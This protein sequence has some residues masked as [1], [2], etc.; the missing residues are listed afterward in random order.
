MRNSFRL[1]LGSPIIA[2]LLGT[3]SAQAGTIILDDFSATQDVGLLDISGFIPSS[4]QTG[5]NSSIL[6]GFR[7]LEALGNADNFLETRLRVDNGVLSFSN[8]VD[9]LGAGSIVWDG[10]DDPTTVDSIGLGGIDITQSGGTDL[11]GIFLDILSADLAGLELAFTVY[12]TNNNTSSLAQIFDTPVAN[13]SP[14]TAG[15]LF[16]DFVG[17]AD[18]T[19]VGAIELAIAGPEEIDATIDLIEIAPS[20]S[21][22]VPEPML[23]IF[24]L[25]GISILGGNSLKHKTQA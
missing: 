18:F 3:G 15:F 14:L 19:N 21:A 2:I 20:E 17:N 12:D 23:S 10:N 6:G 5:P 22:D 1:L 24:A 9:T 16:S 13:S 25:V 11:D 4:S 8:N 7:D